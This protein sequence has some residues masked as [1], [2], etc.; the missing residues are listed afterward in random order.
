MAQLEHK[1][2]D[3]IMGRSVSASFHY[4]FDVVYLLTTTRTERAINECKRVGIEPV[5]CSSIPHSDKIISFNMSMISI[6]K[7]FTESEFDTCLILEDDVQFQNESTAFLGGWDMVYLGGNYLPAGDNTA[8]QYVD[9]NTRRIFN[10][11][12]THA[13]GYTQ[14]AAQWIVANYDLSGIFDDWLNQNIHR[15]K[16]Y[17]TVPMTAVQQPGESSLWERA[18]DYTDIFDRSNDYLTQISHNK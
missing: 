18:V 6:L 13:V 5:V 2:K 14:K 12:T 9:G 1:G 15:F 7:M 4:H 10:A 16:V 3:M 17:A 11:W 8:P